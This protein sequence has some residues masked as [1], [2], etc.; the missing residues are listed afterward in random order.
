VKKTETAAESVAA[1]SAMHSVAEYED[2]WFV[3]KPDPIAPLHD[4]KFIQVAG[5]YKTERA[6]EK[7]CNKLNA[8]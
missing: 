5:P 6:A 2:G 7:K 1:A 4:C 3:E 8:G